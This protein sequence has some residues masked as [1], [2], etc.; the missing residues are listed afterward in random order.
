MVDRCRRAELGTGVDDGRF[1]AE[2]REHLVER[3]DDLH[4]ACRTDVGESDVGELARRVREDAE[5]HARGL[6]AAE[7][8][9]GIAVRPE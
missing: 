4:A 1:V 6:E 7:N 8:R 9:P 2:S 3:S 5:A